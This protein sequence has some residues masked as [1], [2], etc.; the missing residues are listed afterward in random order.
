M[1]A[2]K[3]L[4]AA[5][6]SGSRRLAAGSSSGSRPA[7]AGGARS[8]GVS[9]QGGRSTASRRELLNAVNR[10]LSQPLFYGRALGAGNSRVYSAEASTDVAFTGAG[11]IG[12][13]A[14][15]IGAVVDVR[16]ETGLP[17]ILT[18]LEVQDHN[19]RLV[20]EV[21]QHLGEGTVRTIAMDSTDGL[22]R[23]QKVLNTG[24][25]IKVSRSAAR[26]LSYRKRVNPFLAEN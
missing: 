16:F 2:R 3:A 10:G 1:S 11:S 13:V 9:S 12:A 14:T 15:V 23:G 6:R 5:L 8:Y 4:V 26:L 25:P 21:A 19:I 18:A 7:P 17:P 20:L 24:S 22:V